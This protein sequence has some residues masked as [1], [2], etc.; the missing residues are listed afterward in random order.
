[1]IGNVTNTHQ[2]PT[3]LVVIKLWP[4]YDPQYEQIEIID[5]HMIDDSNIGQ[6]NT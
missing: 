6:T 3:D 1:M 5:R 4:P 2:G